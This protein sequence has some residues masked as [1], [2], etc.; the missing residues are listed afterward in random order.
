MMVNCAE[1]ISSK[2]EVKKVYEVKL[3]R[4]LTKGDMDK[5][6]AGI[7]LEDG[8]V[9]PD[10]IAYADSKDKSIIGVEI[11]SGR[12][13]IVRRIFEHMNTMSKPLTA[14]CLR[15]LQRKMCNVVTGVFERQRA[16]YPKVHEPV[17][18]E[19]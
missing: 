15:V 6:A 19:D 5:I 1:V 17:F 3:D 11:H 2:H 12:N 13:R 16:A 7:T 18:R 14:L 10:V 4:A 8:F 9:A